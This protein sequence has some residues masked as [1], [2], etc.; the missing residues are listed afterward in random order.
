[1]QVEGDIKQFVS[2]V[3]AEVQR[4]GE[5]LLSDVDHMCTAQMNVLST[6]SDK[7]RSLDE[8][9]AYYADFLDFA[10][11]HSSSNVLLYSKKPLICHMRRI[12]QSSLDVAVSQ[13]GF[14]LEF[15]FDKHILTSRV[16]CYGF[17]QLFGHNI[18]GMSDEQ[19]Q[20]FITQKLVHGASPAKK[21]APKQRPPAQRCTPLNQAMQN[22]SN[23]LQQPFPQ[24]SAS[25]PQHA[26][27]HPAGPMTSNMHQSSA[28]FGSGPPLSSTQL[29]SPH[30]SS[31][32]SSTLQR[33]GTTSKWNSDLNSVHVRTLLLF[34]IIPYHVD[35]PQ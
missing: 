11:E 31:A 26:M 16:P 34:C 28:G 19:K 23:L 20:L 14:P 21:Q 7:L 3:I 5:R 30:Q 25:M 12:C 27:M 29:F 10:R 1:M 4:R 17:V 2:Q 32:I 35:V 9:M 24:P 22:L 13:K 8:R 33:M 6:S 15:Q 18:S